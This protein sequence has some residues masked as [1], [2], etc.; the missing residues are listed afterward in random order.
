MSRKFPYGIKVSIR[1][2]GLISHGKSPLYHQFIVRWA[3]R[4]RIL[5]HQRPLSIYVYAILSVTYTILL[6]A[7]VISLFFLKLCP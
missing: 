4:I 7:C 6:V 2:A 5:S 3:M 1:I